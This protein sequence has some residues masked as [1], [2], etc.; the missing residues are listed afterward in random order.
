LL[1]LSLLVAGCKKD[2]NVLGVSVLPGDDSLSNSFTEYPLYAHTQRF[3][4]IA[5]FR[6]QYRFLG[7][8]NDYFGRVDVGLY[9]NANMAGEKP[10][11]DD[12]YELI[13]S[14]IILAIDTTKSAGNTLASLSYSIYPLDSALSTSRVYYS[15]NTSLHNPVPLPTFFTGPHSVIKG[16]P[17]R[18]VVKIPVDLA[19]ADQILQGKADL[20]NNST[21]QLKYKGFYIVAS[22]GQND[23]VIYKVD[24]EDAVSGF[25]INYKK[26][27]DTTGLTFHFT[28]SGPS[29]V[30]INTV[31][32]DYTNATPVLKGQ[33]NGDTTLGSSAFFLKG[34]GVT[35]VRVNIPFLKNYSDSFNVAVNRAEITFPLDPSYNNGA[36]GFPLPP[37]LTLLPVSMAGRD[38]LAL[39]QLNPTDNARYNG[40][41]DAPNNRYIFNIARHAQAILKGEKANNG[42]YLYVADPSKILAG[43]RDNFIERVA[44]AGTGNTA[45][46][47]RFRMNYIRFKKD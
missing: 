21:F 8:T 34:M 11:E 42:F 37:Q 17:D 4:S 43:R 13:S 39:D 19:F 20:Q 16:S 30:K 14:E 18:N 2:H 12:V 33:L 9:L 36:S 3:D 47:P 41:Y 15:N 1:S 32:Y 24:T 46:Q 29:S 25:Y 35:K 31:K 45:N 7:S 26:K 44:L 38:T 27:G 40:F 22:A 6:D 28:F 23:G 5:N 10:F